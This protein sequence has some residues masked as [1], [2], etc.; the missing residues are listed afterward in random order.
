MQKEHKDRPHYAVLLF[1]ELYAQMGRGSYKQLAEKDRN[2]VN[3]Y[4]F[5][6]RSKYN[7]NKVKDAD[8]EVFD[9]L[10]ERRRWA[11]LQIAEKAGEIQNLERQKKYIL[12]P[13][14]YAASDEVYQK[15]PHKGEPKP[16]KLLEKE[17]S[18]Y[19]DFVYL[20]DDRVIVE[21]A[22]GV[23]T[24]EFRIKKKLMLKEYGIAVK[25]VKVA[26]DGI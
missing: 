23:E 9:S 13:A 2:G 19:A 14:Q 22:K 3:M 5:Y 4:N 1:M 16:G 20:K 26:A 17:C 7:A 8:G 6:R 25:V 12:I 10:L 21:D 24:K 11:Y 15:G 18:Y